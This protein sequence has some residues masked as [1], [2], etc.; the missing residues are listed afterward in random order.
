MKLTSV[1]IHPNGSSNIATMSFRDPRRLNPYNVKRIIGLDAD[2][3]QPRYSGSSGAQKF[4]NLS[5]EKRDVV[6][7]V[8]LNPTYVYSEL[9]DNL[10]KLISSSRTGLVEL[11]FKNGE[12]VVAVISGFITKF[13][14]EHFERDQQV[15]LTI[16]CKDPMLKA[17]NAVVVDISDLDPAATTIEDPLSTAPHGMKFEVTVLEPLASFEMRDTSGIDWEFSVDP[18]GGFL[19]DDVVHVSSEYGDRYLYI[20]RDSVTIHLASAIS[21]TASWPIIFP[22]EN[23][24]VLENPTSWD[25]AAISYYPTYWGV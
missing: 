8:E 22:G 3:I 17:P 10:Y 21:P 25:W 16:N 5:L 2:E 14:T 23:T 6:M 7:L 9:R 4:Y 24:F 12:T 18:I 1:E 15:Q 13:E 20:V 19:A 11:W